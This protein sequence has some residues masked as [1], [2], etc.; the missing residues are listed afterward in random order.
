[1]GSSALCKRK[2]VVPKFTFHLT[3]AQEVDSES[4]DDGVH[5]DKLEPPISDIQGSDEGLH[6]MNCSDLKEMNAE[7]MCQ[8]EKG[9]ENRAAWEKLAEPDLEGLS[10]EDAVR[11]LLER[12]VEPVI[13]QIK[14]VPSVLPPPPPFLTPVTNITEPLKPVE[15]ADLPDD[16]TSECYKS[17]GFLCVCRKR[18][19][20]SGY[21]AAS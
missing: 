9:A 14:Q 13:D 11:H 12:H 2:V 5:G 7:K 17:E 4:D 15:I 20:P 3:A 21:P 6:E 10:D 18:N 16:C 8:D 19:W 1:M